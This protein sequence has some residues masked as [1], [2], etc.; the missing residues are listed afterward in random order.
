MPQDGTS[1]LLTTGK[2]YWRSF[3]PIWLYIVLAC[4]TAP[5]AQHFGH[6]EAFFYAVL[7]PMFLW[8]QYRGMRVWLLRLA[9]YFHV[10]FWAMLFPFLLAVFVGYPIHDAIRTAFL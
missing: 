5:L 7:A 4:S 9:P 10:V 3:L 2:R 1:S 8:V 6:G